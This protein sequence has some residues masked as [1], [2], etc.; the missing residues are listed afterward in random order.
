MYI[1]AHVLI[2]IC[3][4]RLTDTLL[5]RL[6]SPIHSY[7]SSPFTFFLLSFLS[8]L[9]SLHPASINL[10]L[11]N[12]QGQICIHIAHQSEGWGGAGK[13]GGKETGRK[14]GMGREGGGEV[15]GREGEAVTYSNQYIQKLL[16]ATRTYLGFFKEQKTLVENRARESE[17]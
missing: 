13:E 3:R 17:R 11:T 5:L 2:L 8:L 12:V 15:P 14:A 16:V 1:H 9:L 7:V 10:V 4:Q 6:L